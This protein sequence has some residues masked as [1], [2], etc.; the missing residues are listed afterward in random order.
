M[1]QFEY[2]GVD[3]TKPQSCS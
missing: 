1:K 2:I 3:N